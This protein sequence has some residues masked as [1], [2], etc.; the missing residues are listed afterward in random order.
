MLYTFAFG[1]MT[2]PYIIIAFQRYDYRKGLFGSE[3]IGVKNFEFFFRSPKFLQISANTLYLNFLFIIASGI[4]IPLLAAIALNE[5]K[6]KLFAK[7]AQ[8]AFLFPTFISW[9]IASYI[10]YALFATDLGVVNQ[11]MKALGL[12]PLNF[13]SNAAPWPYLLVL[14]R[15]WK[16]TGMQTVVYL[17][18]ITGIDPELS[19][20]AIIDGAGRLQVVRRIIMPLLFPTV[21]ILTLLSIGKI[22]YGD[23][24]M[25][26]SIV[27]DNGVL[28]PTTDVIDTYVFRALRKTGD[29][30]QAMAV[31]LYQSFMGFALV[32]LSN[33]IV[34]RRDPSAALF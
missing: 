14:L 19:E 23:F 4:V 8:S 12:N 5:V 6:G 32:F 18:A 22:F 34:R 7:A 16:N 17:A 13:Y 28:L 20:A 25:I 11:L 2:L 10:V 33:W 21:S 30:S 3:F 1:Y 15:I 26:Y 24:G 27:K 29:P 31:G 9:V